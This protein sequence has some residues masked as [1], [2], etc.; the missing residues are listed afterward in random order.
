MVRLEMK[1]CVNDSVLLLQTSSIH[2]G[3]AA[4]S[5]VGGTGWLWCCWLWG[6]VDHLLLSDA[7]T[8]VRCGDALG[9]HRRRGVEV[10]SLAN[11]TEYQVLGTIGQS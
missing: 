11:Q 3:E 8:V 4:W 2:A 6:P 9:Q 7:R 10:N 5:A 1:R